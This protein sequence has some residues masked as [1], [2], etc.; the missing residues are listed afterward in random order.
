MLIHVYIMTN[1][2]TTFVHLLKNILVMITVR[3]YVLSHL[4]YA[5]R[6]RTDC[7]RRNRILFENMRIQSRARP[8]IVQSPTTDSTLSEV[9]VTRNYR[10]NAGENIR[11][12]RKAA[13]FVFNN[14]IRTKRNVVLC[15]YSK[16]K[17]TLSHD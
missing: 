11:S 2:K 6:G 4:A 12:V 10:R 15:R 1:N 14:F 13:T 5:T 9:G 16:K 17:P 7:T 8:G 3:F